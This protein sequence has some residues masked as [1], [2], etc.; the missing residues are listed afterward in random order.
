MSST[1]SLEKVHHATP[2]KSIRICFAEL[3]GNSN[4]EGRAADGNSRS[5]ARTSKLVRESG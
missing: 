1:V 4:D 2:G 5:Q 3:F